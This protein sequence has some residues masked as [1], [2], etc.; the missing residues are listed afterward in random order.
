LF[1][2]VTLIVALSRLMGWIFSRFHQPQV[3][4]EMIAGLILGPSLLGWA[5]PAAYQRLFPAESLQF[6]A[7]L[8]QIGVVFFLFLIGLELDPA[9]LRTRAKAAAGISLAS[10]LFPFV[11]GI[12]FTILFYN[13]LFAVTGRLWA[14]A[15]FMGAAMSIT[16]FPVLAR[17]LTERNLHRSQL[18]V[19]SIACAAIN[20]LAAWCIL[21]VVVAVAKYSSPAHALRTALLAAAYI[22][23]MALAV[24]PFLKRLQLIHQQQGKLSQNMVALIILLLLASA[25]ATERIG[26]HALFGAFV[27]GLVMPKN[28]QFVRHLGEKLEDFI[29]VL[30]L[31]LFFAFTGLNTRIT[32]LDSP[33]MW[34]FALLI[35]AIACTGKFGGAALG[36]RIFKMPW[37]E[38]AAIGVLM[39]TRGL[40]ELI[41]LNI[42][43]ELGLISPQVFAMMVIMA[44]VTTA[45]TT[46]LLN[47]IYPSRMLD[48]AQTRQAAEFSILIPISLPK[49]GGPLVQ[50]ADALI[51]TARAT[52]RL[53]ALHLRRPTEHEAFHPHEQETEAQAALVPLLSQ[54][55][56]RAL[57]V[58]PITFLSNDVAADIAAT[59][60]SRNVNLV[61]MGYHNPIFGKAM[62]GGTVHRV[63]TACA[64][65][66]AVFVDRG[67]RNIDKILVPYLGS[68]HDALAL[69]LAAR[70]AKNTSARV[71]VLNVVPPLTGHANKSADAKRAVEKIFDDP[72][73]KTSL[74][75][76]IVED[77]SPVGVVLHQARDFDLIIIG[78]AEEWGLESR[79]FGWRPEK[80][81][82]DCPASLLIVREFAKPQE[83]TSL[84]EFPHPN[85]QHHPKMAS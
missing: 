12:T 61:L 81:A 50:I 41:I 3:M 47:W 7:I 20:D 70:M 77:S 72:A 63:L 36:A 85:P 1:V 27:L 68:A 34:G 40:M 4:G 13:Q 67:L 32:L 29:V 42:G 31:P 55:H 82:T 52:A 18:G 21:A 51:G 46:P 44:L 58:E 16:A 60:T 71:T 54:A 69:E 26:I 79:L 57:H 45:M 66:V 62:L 9:I 75:F 48:A 76:K 43:R 37:R 39:N 74:T 53:F 33:A 25:F 24:R 28:P 73:Q 22:A 15:L 14:S 6:L 10:I 23:L 2:Q 65:H 84:A 19:I 30:L 83:S 8:S 59:A 49:T 17:I 5:A 38:S 35:I 78:V 64:S 11:L 80:I 56:A